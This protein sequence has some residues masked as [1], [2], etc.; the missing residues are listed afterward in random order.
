MTRTQQRSVADFSLKLDDHETYFA[1]WIVPHLN[2]KNDSNNTQKLI[3]HAHACIKDR[4]Q[5]LAKRRA[6]M[7][8]KARLPNLASKHRFIIYKL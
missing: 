2:H 8:P 7:P 3:T 6:H 5:T 1:T 4:F